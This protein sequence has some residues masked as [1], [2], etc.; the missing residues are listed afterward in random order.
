MLGLIAGKRFQDPLREG[1]DVVNASTH[2]TFFGSQR[3]V[4][5]SNMTDA[6]W[7]KIDKGAFPGSSSNHHLDTLVSLADHDLRVP[8]VRRVLRGPGDA[9]REGAGARPLKSSGFSVEAKEFGYTESHQVAVN[10]KEQG[11]GDEVSPRAQGQ[12]HHH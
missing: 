7:R 6:D 8:G 9:Q 1:A 5:F 12:R 4:I 3:G 10:V 2:K 11:G